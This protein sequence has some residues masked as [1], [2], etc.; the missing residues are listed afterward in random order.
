ME[1]GRSV[2]GRLNGSDEAGYVPLQGKKQTSEVVDDERLW[3]PGRHE[4]GASCRA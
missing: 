2:A 4:A 1:T 3:R